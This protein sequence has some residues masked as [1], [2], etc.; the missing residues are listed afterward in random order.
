VTISIIVAFNKN[1]VIGVNG[2][3]PWRLPEDIAMFKERTMGHTVIM[4]RRTWDSIPEKFRP[5]PGRRNIVLSSKAMEHFQELAETI[6]PHPWQHE[7]DIGPFFFHRFDSAMELCRKRPFGNVFIIGGE[8]IYRHAIKE[9]VVDRVIASIVDNDAAGDAYFPQLD[10]EWK[11][12][13]ASAYDGFIV[14]EWVRERLTSQTE[15][16]PVEA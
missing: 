12:D 6:L 3:I 2:G 14:E 11:V 15:P 13:R 1:R 7:Y 8:Q 9:G 10:P 16:E 5:L 4:G